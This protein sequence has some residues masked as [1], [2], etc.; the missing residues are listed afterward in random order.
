MGEYFYLFCVCF[1]ACLFG[2]VYVVAMLV[3]WGLFL[4]FMFLNRDTIN[5]CFFVCLFVCF[6]FCLFVCLFVCFRFFKG[7]VLV[8]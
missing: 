4:R 6:L 5:T 1:F 3:V 7:T 8:D 2:F